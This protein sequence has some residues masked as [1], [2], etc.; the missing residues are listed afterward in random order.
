MCESGD[1]GSGDSGESEY[2]SMGSPALFLDG[3]PVFKYNELQPPP[4]FYEVMKAEKSKERK[5]RAASNEEEYMYAYAETGRCLIGANYRQENKSRAQ[6]SCSANIPPGDLGEFELR[7]PGES[8]LEATPNTRRRRRRLRSKS[9]DDLSVYM[10]SSLYLD[11]NDTNGNTKARRKSERDEE[12]N[13]MPQPFTGLYEY[14][15]R[16]HSQDPIVKYSVKPKMGFPSTS[17]FEVSRTLAD[18]SSGSARDLKKLFSKRKK[19]LRK[20]ISNP[21]LLDDDKASMSSGRSSTESSP[22]LY[23]KNRPSPITYLTNS[24]R[25]RRKKNKKE[26][27]DNLSMMSEDGGGGRGGEL[28]PGGA[29]NIKGV[30]I[31]QGKAKLYSRSKNTDSP[32]TSRRTSSS[33]Y[34]GSTQHA[35]ESEYAHDA[36]AAMDRRSSQRKSGKENRTASKSGTVSH[37]GKPPLSSTV[38]AGAAADNAKGYTPY[39]LQELQRQTGYVNDKAEGATGN[40][41]SDDEVLE[42]VTGSMEGLVKKEKYKERYVTKPPTKQKPVLRT[43]KGTS[44]LQRMNG[45]SSSVD[46]QQGSSAA[47]NRDAAAFAA[48][49]MP[50]FFVPRES[51]MSSQGEKLIDSNA[52]KAPEQV[53][54]SRPAPRY[55]PFDVTTGQFLEDNLDHDLPRSPSYV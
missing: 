7:S 30:H 16:R 3:A 15:D 55:L 2:L 23:R 38:S 40:Y 25:R 53:A 4:S 39:L 35:P 12:E 52:N 44:R 21:N 51:S 37:K 22:S 5:Q 31:T 27:E 13:S 48:R 24:L 47:Y 19:E 6:K 11:D 26:G 18:A 54:P 49:Q 17:D 14:T 1:R 20:A 41:E 9:C 34:Q 10:R 28:P 43:V 32:V 42:D 50:I 29:V 45:A 8:D 46:Y 33:S 36:A